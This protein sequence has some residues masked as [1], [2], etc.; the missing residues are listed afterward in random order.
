LSAAVRHTMAYVPG[1]RT[2]TFRNPVFHFMPFFLPWNPDWKGDN[3]IYNALTEVI[4]NESILL[5]QAYGFMLIGRRITQRIGMFSR[6]LMS[7][8][9][10]CRNDPYPC[11]PEVKRLPLPDD[12]VPWNVEFTEYAPTEYTAPSVLRQPV[13]ADYDIR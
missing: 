7:T 10:K 4:I 13:W 12:K 8:H 1:A 3:L 5:L 6:K 11:N 2:T 9:Q